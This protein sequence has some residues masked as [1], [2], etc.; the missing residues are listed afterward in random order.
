MSPFF[1]ANFNKYIE[2]FLG[3]GA[4]F[5][6]LQPEKAIL[7]DIND[8][9]MNCY[10]VIK[11]DVFE[12]IEL[13]KNHLKN[14]TI[15]NLVGNKTVQCAINMGL[16]DPKCVLRIKGVPHAQIVKMLL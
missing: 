9:L 4:I 11:N 5:F 1:P 3:G 12:L 14:A 16:V 8:E 2:P 6:Y 10:R 7:I 13:L 15:A